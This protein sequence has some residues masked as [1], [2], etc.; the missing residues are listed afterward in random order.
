MGERQASSEVKGGEGK[1][2]LDYL[3]LA[4]AAALAHDR[5]FPEQPLKESKALDV[6]ALALSALIPFYQRDAEHGTL[7]HLDE[8]EL[9]AGRFTRGATTVEFPDRAPLR[10]LVVSREA[11]YAAIETLR[12]DAPTAG[13]LSLTLR[14]RPRMSQR[15]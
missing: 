5:L 12:E 13:R 4:R 3:P 2:V 10:F 6:I 15:P 7:R 9:V 11:L 1:A 8:A 14:H